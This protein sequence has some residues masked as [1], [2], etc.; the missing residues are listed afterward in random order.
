VA[1]ALSSRPSSKELGAADSASNRRPSRAL[2]ILAFAAVY[3]IWGSTYLAIKYAIGTLPP[4]LMAGTRFLSA[5]A[6]LFAW[7]SVR[8]ERSDTKA[9]SSIA[10][11]QK[12]FITGALLLLCGNGG[13]TWAERYL[14]SG[15]TALL[16]ATEP[17]W[18]V[19]LNWAIVGRRG[20]ARPNAKVL[21]G[22]FIGLAGVA[23]LVSG[24]FNGGSGS[25]AMNWIGAAIVV[26][27]ALAWAGGSVYSIRRPI[28]ASA[29]L[30]SG[31]QMLAGG[32]L[33]ILMGLLSEEYRRLHLSHAS[34]LSIGA[35]F[36]LIVFGSIV[37]FTAYSWLLRTV[38]PARAATYAYVNPV[39]AV[40]LG[41]FIASEPVTLRMLL[42]A[43]VIVGSVALI[44]TYGKEGA[45]KLGA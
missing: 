29:P 30:A 11:W 38:S 40:L 14:P 3:L 5:G 18:V 19:M 37:A 10:Q 2:I 43:V 13:V 17:L 25:A 7:A 21:V 1:S 32:T 8:G 4:F 27:A 35:L 6:L 9:R 15:L 12:A 36:Y 34:W 39:V 23:V 33:L 42:A 20:G 26:A 24:G 45:K 22:L 31:M 44:T 16:V 41:W 28:E